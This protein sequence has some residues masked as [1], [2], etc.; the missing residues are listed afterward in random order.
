MGLFFVIIIKEL[1]SYEKQGFFI[2]KTYETDGAFS[3]LL[4]SNKKN[5]YMKLTNTQ[6]IPVN[7]IITPSIALNKVFFCTSKTASTM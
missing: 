5:N 3:E 6:Y 2:I 4:K 1:D 7:V